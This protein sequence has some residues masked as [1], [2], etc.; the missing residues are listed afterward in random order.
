MAVAGLLSLATGNICGADAP[1]DI[2]SRRD[3][4]VDRY[5]LERLDHVSL[6]LHEPRDGSWFADGFTHVELNVP[7]QKARGAGLFFITCA[8]P[9]SEKE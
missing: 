5:L 8:F 9:I 6:K 1:L 2:G 4:F 3:L 7:P